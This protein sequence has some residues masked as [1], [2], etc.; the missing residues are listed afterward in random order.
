MRYLL[1]QLLT[2]TASRTPEKTAVVCGG[3][4]LTYGAL[5]EASNR[6]ARLLVDHHIQP[7]DR[8]AFWFGKSIRSVITM[9]G[10]LKAGAAYVPVDPVAPL[11]RVLRVVQNSGARGLVTDGARLNQ[12]P[13][14]DLASTAV[15]FIVLA[16]EA[17]EVASGPRALPWAALD[18]YSPALVP[19]DGRVETD[20]AYILYTSGS[21]GVPKGVMLTHR[22]ALTFIDW[23][24]AT[25]AVGPED[26]LSNHAPLHFDLSVFD[27]Y[28]AI[29][30]GATVYMIDE[31]TVVFPAAVA[32]L[33]AA[34][35]ITI[36]YSVPSALV[37]LQLHGDLA[38]R[39][40][41]HLRLVLYAG[42]PFPLKHLRALTEMLR[43]IPIYNLYGPTETNVC[44]Y[45]RVPSPL[46]PGIDQIP[47]GR[48]CSNTEAIALN[49]NAKPVGVGEEG[50]LY[51]RGPS[52]TP[53]YWGDEDRTRSVVLL[54]PN[55][56][57][58]GDRIYRTGDIVRLAEDGNFLF[59]GRRDNMV[60]SR[61]YRIELGEIEAALYSHPGVIEAA[62]FPVPDEEIG[63]RLRAFVV[64]K[65][66]SDVT[67]VDLIHHC[68][69]QIPRYMLPEKVDICEHL[70]RT[71]TGKIDRLGLSTQI[72][73]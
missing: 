29:A 20:L 64:L 41:A 6:L 61:G 71:S 57:Y 8:I 38:A 69:Q 67:A 43:G 12:V 53:G 48:A 24:A 73:S 25:F 68:S 66:G 7:G 49:D 11:A 56:P 13:G 51:I 27:I 15:E 34:S 18:A 33:M 40:L 23:C 9:F 21:T 31:R 22:N 44:T 32:A 45:Y 4:T 50:E 55:Q 59:V 16:D 62:V 52:V 17:S 47:I 1:P 28:N 63:N 39:Q 3:Q 58:L 70:P 10:V 19:I 5:E 14:A 65:P 46:L 37:G 35:E 36:W 42:E 26:R 72:G 30:A 60:K 54:N 2:S